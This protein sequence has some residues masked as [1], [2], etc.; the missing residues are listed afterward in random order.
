[1]A[2][3]THAPRRRATDLNAHVVFAGGGTAGHLFPGLAVAKHL[4]RGQCPPRITFAGSGKA[5]ERRY[6]EAGG[7]AYV[8]LPCRAT[9]RTPWAAMRFCL[10]HVRG[11]FAARR[12]I[13]RHGVALVVGLGGYA[14]VP[15]ARAAVARGVPLVLLEQ[16]AVP[17]KTT[18]WL[19]PRARLVCAAFEEARQQM[20]SAAEL[21]ITGNPVAEEFAA[22]AELRRRRTSQERPL[23]TVLGGSQGSHSLN[24]YVPKA[25]ARL[26]NLVR[27]QW[28]IVHQAGEDQVAATQQSYARLDLPAQVVPFV[29]DMPGLLAT[30]DL[31]ISRAGGTTLAELAVAGLPAVLVPYPHAADDHQMANARVYSEAGGCRVVDCVPGEN[32]LDTKL[33]DALEDLMTDAAVR[34]SMGAAMERMSRPKAAGDVVSLLEGLLRPASAASHE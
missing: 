17:G 7:F 16:N 34:A 2:G 8:P 23:L 4:A 21:K 20:P 25:L 5:F 19:A 27:G 28:R 31:V 24:Q 29:H 30:T 33:A 18:R 10:D 32:G 6:V 14:S 11:Q 9:P 15:M 13:R 26:G 3:T 1:M 12:F 22:V